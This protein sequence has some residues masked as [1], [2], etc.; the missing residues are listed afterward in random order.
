MAN[1]G[2]PTE[3]LGSLCLKVGSGATP[4]GGSKVY[5]DK[6]EIALIRSQN[7]YNDGFNREGLVYIT[8]EHAEQLSNVT[9][10]PEDVLLNIT[11][12]SVARCCQV[13]PHVLPARVNQHVSIIRPKPDELIPRFLRYFLVS[14]TM[15]AQMLSWAHAGATRK[16]LTK[17]M[18]ESFKVTKPDLTIQQRIAH[19]LGT[20]DD[21]IELNRR[22][23]RTLEKMAA[24]IFKSWFIDF[25][26][27]R[28]KAEGQ[29]TGLPK[30]IA[31]LFPDSFE[32][33]EIGP[34]PKGWRLVPL[35]EAIEVNP[36]KKLRR[37]SVATYIEMKQMPTILSRPA[38]WRRRKFTSS[39]SKFKNGDVLLARITPCLEN[40][41]TAFVDF[42]KDG[43]VGWGST[44]YIVLRSKPP[45]P[46]EFTYLLAR[47]DKFREHAIAN[48][49]GTSGRQRVPN[50]SFDRFLVCI[51]TEDVARAFESLV[52]PIFHKTKSNDFQSK[53]LRKLRNTLL[54]KLLSG[55]LEVPDVKN[56]VERLA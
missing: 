49:T 31:D 34:I 26:P 51:P 10:E 53:I 2:F 22:M 35:P 33:S 45:L 23:N 25:D 6:G 7:V 3:K 8:A 24:A 18:I 1:N 37:G 16:A 5:L 48:M 11:G 47:S 28:A 15:Q 36:P 9:V 20:L 41:K 29:D 12:D 19:I 50:S 46:P 32:D 55:E 14:P 30:E 4:R 27:V 54:P 52:R 42:L 21:K 44:E 40:G 56:L 39:G 38:K 13:D 43:E 17:G